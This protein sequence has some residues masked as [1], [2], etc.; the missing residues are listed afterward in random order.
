[1]VISIG[2]SG[3]TRRISRAKKRARAI[4]F[5]FVAV[6]ILIVLFGAL[7]LEGINILRSYAAGESHWSKGQKAA[8]FAL[9]RFARSRDAADYAQFE[10]GLLAIEGDRIARE[11]LEQAKGFGTRAERTRAAQGFVLSGNDV[12]DADGLVWGFLLFHRWFT[13]DAAVREWEQGDKW[14]DGLRAVGAQMR[15]AG[16]RADMKPYL[17]RVNAL[18]VHLSRNASAYAERMAQA[19]RIAKRVTLALFVVLSGL[20]CGI[21]VLFVRRIAAAGGRAET[22]AIESEERVRDFAELASD[23]FCELDKD[24]RVKL[25]ATRLT[26]DAGR[27]RV[28]GRDWIEAGRAQGFRPLTEGQHQQALAA[29]EPFR[30]HRFSQTLPDGRELHWSVAGK[31]LFAEDGTFTGFRVT[32]TEIGDMVRVQEE[33]VAARDEAMRAN[34]AKSAFLANM[35][36]ELRT[37]LNAI[38]G[39]STFIEHQAMGEIANK[40]YVEY[41]GDIRES[42]EHLLAIINDLLEHSRIEAG[43]IELR[44]EL[45]DIQ[46]ACEQARLFC[47]PRADKLG[48]TLRTRIAPGLP[49]VQG[50]ELRIRQVLINLVSNAVKFT[51]GGTVDMV[52]RVDGAGAL[53]LDVRDTGIGMDAAGVEQALKPFG[54]VDSGLSRKFEGTGLGLPLA[55]SLVEL[56]GGTLAIV[57]EQ[58]AGTVVSVVL[59][60]WRVGGNASVQAAE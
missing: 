25:V 51:P 12:E 59:P 15:A 34:K 37:P 5:V 9:H 56:H 7:G 22:R 55:K 40:R 43:K 23:W 45:F 2:A 46:A 1:V 8:V 21:G 35:S 39:F 60:A 26:G 29:R 41:A 24:L 33:L 58:G 53:R 10:Q 19:S 50:D 14:A 17:A 54:Q 20:A 13:F 57:S 44:E 42:G 48:V 18:D 31:P 38:L 49:L 36:H 6:Q 28:T 52:A 11:T 3:G 27:A 32:G 47:Q 4:A 16:P 30:G